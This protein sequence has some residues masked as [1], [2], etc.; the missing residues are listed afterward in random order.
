MPRIRLT[1][2]HRRTDGFDWLLNVRSGVMPVV[3][4]VGDLDDTFTTAL[5]PRLAKAI[6][7]SPRP[8]KGLLMTNPHNPFGRCYPRTVIEQCLKFCQEHQI[9]YISD[10]VYG[11]SGFSHPTFKDPIP[12]TSV[13]SV[14]AAALGC[15]PWRVHVVWSISKDFG[16]SG[17][18]MVS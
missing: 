10:E 16:S 15:D 17:L 6:K 2:A 1:G 12:F 5:L 11:L 4:D 8:I 3:V 7:D 18:R 14:D 9:H 13:L